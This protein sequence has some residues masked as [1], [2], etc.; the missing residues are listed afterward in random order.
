[1]TKQADITVRHLKVYHDPQKPYPFVV[2][3]DEGDD[4][5]TWGGS[6]KTAEAAAM[7]VADWLNEQKNNTGL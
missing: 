3:C 6:F 4:P 1:M 5:G 2:D 7:M